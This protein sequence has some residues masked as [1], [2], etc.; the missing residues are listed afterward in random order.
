MKNAQQTMKLL[1]T[2][3]RFTYILKKVNSVK[4]LEVTV[5]SELTF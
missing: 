3:N 1:V 5:D 2:Q 4:D